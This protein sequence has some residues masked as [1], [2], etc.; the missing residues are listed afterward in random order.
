MNIGLKFARPRQTSRGKQNCSQDF[1][2]QPKF[3]DKIVQ[4]KKNQVLDSA[5]DPPSPKFSCPVDKNK[6]FTTIQMN[7]CLF[8]KRKMIT[9]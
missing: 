1:P 6:T 7:A 3:Q 4:A 8:T 5:T 2:M 9:V